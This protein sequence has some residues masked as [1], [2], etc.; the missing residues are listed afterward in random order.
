MAYSTPPSKI[1]VECLTLMAIRSDST[2]TEYET[3]L[4]VHLASWLL[5]EQQIIIDFITHV[6]KG[7]G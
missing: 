2:V 5:L 3:M 6:K 7:M 1:L 4:E